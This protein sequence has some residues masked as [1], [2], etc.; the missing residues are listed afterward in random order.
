MCV[1][2]IGNQA[3][4]TLSQRIPPD[5]GP[6]IIVDAGHGGEDGGAT[7]C[8]GILESQF[9]LEISLRLND[10]LQFLGFETKMVRTTDHAVH[11]EGETIAARKRSDLNNRV[12]LVNHTEDA[13]LLSIH[14][15]TFPDGRYSG[16]QV[17][18][19]KDCEHIAKHFQTSLNQNLY[20]SSSRQAK[21]A[22]G[23]FLMEHITAPGI[24]IECG[25]LSNAQEEAKLR[26]TTYQQKL[27]C[28]IVSALSE[29][30]SNT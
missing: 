22:K 9:N 15:N 18:Y 2:H 26:S 6:C 19:G 12:K 10:L 21:T 4:T 8:S 16:P 17:F 27:C 25:F 23:I 28:V 5:R 3:V 30:L 13:F 20:P 7:S 14:Q 24:L 1:I 11:T 29:Y